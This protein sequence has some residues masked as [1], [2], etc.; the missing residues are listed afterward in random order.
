MEILEEAKRR[1][2]ASKYTVV[3]TGAGISAESGIPTFRGKGGIWEKYPPPFFG[4]PIGIILSFLFTPRRVRDF[5]V[6]AGEMFLNA[7]PNRGHI[8]IAEMERKGIVKSVITQN[9][10]SLH[11]K[12]GSRN[13]VKLHGNAGKW[14]CMRCG[15]KKESSKEE[16]RAVIEEIRTVSG[17]VSFIQRLRRII[18]S[19]ECGGIMRPDVVLFMESLPMREWERAV[20]EAHLCDTM[21]I[22]GTSGV[23]YPAGRIPFIAKNN[24]AFL[25]EVNPEPSSLTS[26]TELF[27]KGRAGEILP[28]LGRM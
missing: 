7:E 24:R 4:N 3:F 23:V 15:K 21:L 9:I 12:A 8:A 28:E 14:R 27:I 25:I 17:R 16:M 11:E 2:K 18:P 26:F 20:S 13:V 1:L 10:D 5:I 22:V 19:C 6:D